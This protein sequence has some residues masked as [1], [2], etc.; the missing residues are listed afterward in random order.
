[1]TKS[2]T[3]GNYI[4]EWFGQRIFPEV[5]LNDSTI[6]GSH[7][8][9]CPFLSGVK[10]ERTQCIKSENAFGVCTINSVG[11]DTRRDWL[12]CP[13]RVIDSKIVKDGCETIFKSA[14]S[15]APIPVSILGDKRGFA[16]L[17][18]SLDKN[19]RAFVFFQDKLG[20]EISISGTAASPEVAFDVTTVEITR[21][22]GALKLG[23]Y[24]FIEI[25]TMDFHGSYKHAVSNLRD[26]HR[27]HKKDF[28][29]ALKENPSW[30]SQ[31]VEGPNIANVF[32]RTFYQTLLKFELSKEGAAAGT[33]LALPQSVWES[34]QP[35]LGRP[36]IEHVDGVHY[37]IKGRDN[38]HYHGTNAWIFIFDLD[39]RSSKPIS[40]V[41]IIAKIRVSGTD[42]IE[43]AFV[44]VPK[45]M[46][47][48]A[49]T[50][51][52][53]LSRIRS[54]IQRVLPGITIS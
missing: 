41:N 44:N 40:P 11:G 45:N 47:H 26:A 38:K 32:K 6:S 24:G 39:E 2:P 53:L 22:K 18:E 33:I 36:K 27:L 21:T 46:L 13:Y 9:V 20:G 42:L 43:H 7:W 35:F 34:W 4:S 50:K 1:M 23:Q 15:I 28:S 17:D 30:M 29:K 48:L 12:V 19:Q 49:T 25:Q 16:L 54:R 31:G 51:D 10:R 5:R 14:A 52:A 37:R 3:R 8:G